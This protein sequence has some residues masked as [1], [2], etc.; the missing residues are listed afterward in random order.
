MTRQYYY[1]VSVGKV[2]QYFELANP[3]IIQQSDAMIKSL[4]KPIAQAVN[5]ALLVSVINQ[6]RHADATH[7]CSRRYVNENL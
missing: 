6:A 3:T 5:R 1:L 7:R 4:P 2:V